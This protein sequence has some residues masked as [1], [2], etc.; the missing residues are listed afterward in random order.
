MF[1]DSAISKKVE[2]NKLFGR[3]DYN[4][5]LE[6]Y[7]EGLRIDQRVPELWHNKGAALQMLG[8]LLEAKEALE[9]AL[10]LRHDYSKAKQRLE[11]IE[12]SFRYIYIPQGRAAILTEE[13]RN[14][15]FLGM[16]S[17]EFSSCVLAVFFNRAER[18]TLYCHVDLILVADQV[19]VDSFKEVLSTF[20][21]GNVVDVHYCYR[22]Q[23]GKNV[24]DS[25]H[26]NIVSPVIGS[27][28]NS[29]HPI[30]IMIPSGE[31]PLAG[32]F[33]DL[34]G[35]SACATQDELKY[36]LA[37]HP[38][39]SKIKSIRRIEEFVTHRA[40][41]GES[42]LQPKTICIFNE[43][44]V[45]PLPLDYDLKVSVD[46]EGK[47]DED[48]QLFENLDYS[49]DSG[50]IPGIIGAIN[51]LVERGGH[52]SSQRPPGEHAGLLAPCLKEYF[53]AENS[54][55]TPAI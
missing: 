4:G 30:S 48:L 2:G 31:Y 51:T 40:L 24:L 23:V 17:D 14:R 8:R 52:V 12:S 7:E 35:C 55:V 54:A 34:G 49:V 3:G 15:G 42:P 37:Y 11:S 44:W 43:G 19:S 39:H 16:Y 36:P 29:P 27:I 47:V 9:G 41:K 26:S 21:N 38:D 1:F 53:L 46:T 25:L 20:C 32:M 13:D 18:K 28:T 45:Q 50:L 5:A 22:E 33:A 6:R 10:A